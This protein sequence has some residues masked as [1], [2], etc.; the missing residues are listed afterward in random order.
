MTQRRI[1]SE[2]ENRGHPPPPAAQTAVAD[3]VNAPVHAVQLAPPQPPL[4]PPLP[5]P[6]AE[7][8]LPR[9]DSVLPSRERSEKTVG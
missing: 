4:D 2:G 3:C 7:N 1:G 5:K 8:L 6:H 9:D